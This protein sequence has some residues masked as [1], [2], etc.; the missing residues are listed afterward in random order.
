MEK[1]N[2]K[3]WLKRINK[4]AYVMYTLFLCKELAII[5]PLGGTIS[6]FD[7]LPGPKGWPNL[8]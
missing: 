8:T 2:K 7:F 6:L 4:I 5:Y 1:D 3:V